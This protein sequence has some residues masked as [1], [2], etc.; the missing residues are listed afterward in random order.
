MNIIMVVLLMFLTTASAQKIINVNN[1]VLTNAV[2]K[3]QVSLS[4]YQN[5]KAIAI[6]FTSNYCPYSKLYEDRIEKL[7]ASYAD[8]GIQFVLVNSNNPA[9]SKDDSL[10]EMANKANSRSFSFPYLA[11]KEQKLQNALGASKTPEVFLV[12]PQP[13]EFQI[14]Y[15]GAIDNNPQVEKDVSKHY[16]K[17]AIENVLKG[18]EVQVKNIRTTGCMIKKN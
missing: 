10:E 16:L 15:S 17:D 13:N 3:Q 9:A 18:K 6:I 4:E 2:T 11:D 5:S 14:I 1:I 12:R 7:A 8:K